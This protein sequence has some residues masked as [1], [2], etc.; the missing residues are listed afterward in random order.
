MV[1]VNYVL[2]ALYV[3]CCAHVL[4]QTEADKSNDVYCAQLFLPY[5]FRVHLSRQ[6]CFST[7]YT[8]C[9]D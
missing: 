6:A 5:S 8:A 7:L 4:K 2:Y 3:M 1:L 9:N